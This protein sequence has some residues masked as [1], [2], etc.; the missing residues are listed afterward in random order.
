M[1]YIISLSRKLG[2]TEKPIMGSAVRVDLAVESSMVPGV[3]FHVRV[4]LG[5][6]PGSSRIS[7]STEGNEIDPG[8]LLRMLQVAT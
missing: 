5:T 2:L 4:C 8:E 7:G 3:A 1:G 6:Y